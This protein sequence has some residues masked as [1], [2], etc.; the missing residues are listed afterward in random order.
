MDVALA[1]RFAAT[2]GSAEELL[3]LSPDVVIGDAFVPPA[4]RAALAARGIRLVQLPI[5]DSVARA[6]AQV[7]EIARLAG[8]EQAGRALDARIDAA[9]ASA[10]PPRG[11]PPVSA[12]VWQAGGIV[13]GRNTLVADL[14]AHTGFTLQSAA[15]GMGQAD[16]LPLEDVL[17]DPPRVLLVAGKAGPRE[18]R[19]LGHPALAALTHTKR[20]ALD[21]SLLWCGGPTVVR[22]AQR[23]AAI[24]RSL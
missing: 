4:T 24:R 23:L 17:A 19:L 22:A 2:S 16:Y 14:L 13:P 20:A 21:P 18:N 15:R 6:K 11:A 7:L 9:L 10:A 1:R 12:I 3:S 5:V 8:R